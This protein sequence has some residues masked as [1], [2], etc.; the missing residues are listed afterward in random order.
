[1]ATERIDSAR[2]VSRRAVLG[3]IAGAAAVTGLG[4]LGAPL[5]NGPA[6]QG[7]RSWQ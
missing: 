5:A 4:L 2:A 3:G 6:A 7:I 1:M